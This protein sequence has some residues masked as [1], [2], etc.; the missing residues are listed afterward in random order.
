MFEI[1]M[2]FYDSRNTFKYMVHLQNAVYEKVTYLKFLR[3]KSFAS[4]S[5]WLIKKQKLDLFI[6]HYLCPGFESA[7]GYLS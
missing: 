1:F 6:T 4:P 5:A 3:V 7:P 2:H